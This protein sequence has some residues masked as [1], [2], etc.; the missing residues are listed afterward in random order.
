M[1]WS[2]TVCT[3]T[4]ESL[5]LCPPPYNSPI[6]PLTHPPNRPPCVTHLWEVIASRDQP[7]RLLLLVH[8]LIV[9]QRSSLP[10]QLAVSGVGI[11]L[12]PVCLH[13]TL[14]P[15]VLPPAVGHRPALPEVQLAALALEAAVQLAAAAEGI[16]GS[17]IHPHL[18]RQV[19]HVQVGD[20]VARDVGHDDDGLG[21]H[22]HGGSRSLGDSAADNGGSL[23]VGGAR[24]VAGLGHKGGVDP[25]S[26]RA[27][28]GGEPVHDVFGQAVVVVGGMVGVIF[29]KAVGH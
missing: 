15:L 7:I 22:G 26:A 3:W 14:L 29:C 4:P 12:R 19:K 18:R 16:A 13:S 1:L 21:D 6:H 9:H 11:S 5:R 8:R 28:P 10:V 27:P 24:E 17:P 25:G 2:H 23:V 20:D